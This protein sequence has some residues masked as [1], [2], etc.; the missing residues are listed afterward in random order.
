MPFGDSFA[1]YIQII[2]SNKNILTI[3]VC[4]FQNKMETPNGCWSRTTCRGWKLRSTFGPS[5]P[6]STTLPLPSTSRRRWIVPAIGCEQ[7][8]WIPSRRRGRRIGERAT[9]KFAVAASACSPRFSF[10]TF[11]GPSIQF[12]PSNAFD[13][14]AASSS[15]TLTTYR[16][17]TFNI[18]SMRSY[19]TSQINCGL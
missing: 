13:S 8:V 3:L 11:V 12:A 6:S 9:E 10:V 16:S 5:T 1:L 17:L 19:T 15:Y 4:L 14:K 2:I 7:L 18:C